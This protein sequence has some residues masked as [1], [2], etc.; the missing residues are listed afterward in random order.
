MLRRCCS[1]YPQ[2]SREAY[3][4]GLRQ[5]YN[6]RSMSDEI[7]SPPTPTQTEIPS[8]PQ[9]GPSKRTAAEKWHNPEGPPVGSNFGARIL[10]EEEDV[11]NHNAWSAPSLD[12]SRRY[13]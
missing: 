5:T 6:I 8:S 7:S 9:A 3:S 4:T 2:Y 1:S 13:S 10:K 11:W 12:Y